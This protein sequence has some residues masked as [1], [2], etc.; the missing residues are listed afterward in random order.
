M[1]LKR[2]AVI[3]A[4]GS[5][6]RFWPLSRMHRPKQLLC[7]TSETDSLLQEAVKRIA[8]LIPP[9]DVYI[10]TG[11]H[12]QSVIQQANIGVPAENVLAE[13]CKRNTSGCLAYAT[14]HLLAKYHERAEDVTLAVLTAD[15]VI[16]D[17]DAFR[18]T[19]HSALD[20]AEQ[21]NALVTI[22]ITPTRPATGYGYIHASS[23]QGDILTVKAFH[24]KPSLEKAQHYLD[25]G[26]FYWNSGM[27]FWKASTF[28]AELEQNNPPLAQVTRSMA[29]AMR[30]QDTAKVNTIFE[31]IEDLSIDY[32]LMEK[33]HCVRM[34]RARFG[35]DDIGTW[36]A[37]D[38][39]RTPDDQ[40]NVTFG[41]PVLVE[42][43][44]AI[45]Y[46]A[47]GPGKMTVGVVGLDNIIVV[48]TEDAV[49]VL[50]K[51]RSEDVRA[52]LQEL[53]RRN[54]GKT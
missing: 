20:A 42:C 29:E 30:Q 17:P 37:L 13:P 9:E 7:L 39:T 4:G 38:R 32:A 2:V 19:V 6:E 52:V 21:H 28:L 18:A 16:D 11:L 41:S 12:L 47:P 46:N 33:T 48:A 43:H 51:N 3:M 50:P 23:S 25:S 15:H 22:G 26:E 45:V 31:T 34:A 53:R 8:P 36:A 49:L 14:A 54:I 1:S 40:G 24:E 27:F 44:N 5:G 35:W 10:Q